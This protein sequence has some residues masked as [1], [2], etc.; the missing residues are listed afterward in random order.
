MRPEPGRDNPEARGVAHRECC[1][2]SKRLWAF[3]DGKTL[4]PGYCE[5]RIRLYFAELPE[6]AHAQGRDPDEN[7]FPVV[8]SAAEVEDGI[9]SGAIFDSKT[10]SARLCWKFSR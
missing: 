8:L 5:E 7:I 9:R 1:A 6:A 2:F 10:L 3:A 4:H